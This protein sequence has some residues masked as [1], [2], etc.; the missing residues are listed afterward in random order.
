MGSDNSGVEL[1]KLAGE[2]FGSAAKA[3]WLGVGLEAVA[4]GMAIGLNGLPLGSGESVAGAGLVAV[5]A[6]V[7][8]VSRVVL[9]EARQDLGETMRRQSVLTEGLGWDVAGW[10]L[11]EWRRMAGRKLR[12]RAGRVRAAP[13]YY[14]S[15]K[16][17]GPERLGEMTLESCFYTRQV[18]LK[19]RAMIDGAVIVGAGAYLL[20]MG[21]ALSRTL[22]ESVGL[23]ISWTIYALVPVVLGADLI[24]WELRLR[25]RAGAMFEVERGLEHASKGSGKVRES[26]ILRLVA[27]YNCQV[28]DGVPIPNLVFG[29]WHDEI[30][31]LWEERSGGVP[32]SKPVSGT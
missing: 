15:S 24:G 23:M 29:W 22:P 9:G 11:T 7:G 13:D 26:E 19:L 12:K 14:A 25:R 17:A 31:E 3:W 28:A 21:I 32:G 18:Y 20:T 8:Y 6:V 2:L 10:Q 16:P 5:V 4:G 30:R 1:R 27:E